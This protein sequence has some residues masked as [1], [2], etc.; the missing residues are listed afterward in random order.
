[1]TSKHKKILI[2]GASGFIGNRL[3]IKLNKIPEYEVI[4]TYYKKPLDGFIKLNISSK[5]SVESILLKIKPEVII[6]SAGLKNLSITEKS[7]SK[8]LKC[9]YYSVKNVYSYIKSNPATHFIFFSTDYVFKGDQGNYKPDQTP[10][11]ITNYGT[12]KWEAEKFIKHHFPF[13]SIIRTSAVIGKGSA[14]FDWI[15]KSISENKKLE[16][17]THIFSPTPIDLFED[18]VENM[19]NQKKSGTYH[20]SGNEIM[21]RYDLGLLIAKCCGTKTNSIIKADNSSITYF[22][23]NLSLIPSKGLKQK[24]SLKEFIINELK[25]YENN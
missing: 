6:W 4:G 5:K 21:S 19:L 3:Y 18:G 23:K 8:S 10:N 11:P 25:E 12:S 14:F 17:F 16:L 15:Y 2:I 9:N 20:I 24:L 22:H 1:M 13:Y 7:K